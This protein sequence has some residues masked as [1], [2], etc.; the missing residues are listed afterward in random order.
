[1]LAVSFPTEEK[2]QMFVDVSFFF[3]QCER[4]YYVRYSKV[5]TM[6]IFSYEKWIVFVHT[7]Q[8]FSVKKLKN[9]L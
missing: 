9:T 6:V 4:A 5:D 3:V 2:S 8:L 1:M 7:K